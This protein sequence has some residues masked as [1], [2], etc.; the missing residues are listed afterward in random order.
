MKSFL[1]FILLMTFF[2]L[3]VYPDDVQ[4]GRTFWI[5]RFMSVSYP[6]K[7]VKVTSSYGTRKD[8]FTGER[9]SHSGL[10][11]KADNESVMAMFDGVVE[12]YGYDS[13]SGHYVIIRHGIYTVSYCHLSRILVPKGEEVLAGDVVGVSGSTGRSTGP[14]LHITAKRNGVRVDPSILL[15]YISK[16]RSEA[17]EALGGK[18]SLAV[19]F[20]D[21]VGCEEFLEHYS[22]LAMEQQR[23][24]GIPASVTL[25]QMAY[26]SGWGKSDL[27]RKGKNFFGIKANRKWLAAGKPYSVHDDDKK[28]EKFCN[29]TT[30]KESVEHNSRLL[31]SDRYKDCR[32]CKPTD[33]HGW[34]VALKK[35]GYATAK[36]YVPLC[37][38]IIRRYKLYRYDELANKA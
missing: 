22:E 13:R 25:S 33:Y 19:E 4:E 26:E 32:R 38:K 20:M 5:D 37:E 35:G 29:Y 14:H 2:A 24:Y 36:N 6:L 27:A 28:G 9:S 18:P 7:T 17:I 21:G 1:T 15:K 10:D 34:L 3:P 30:V 16:V 12:D 11:L 8:P 31:M 23:Q